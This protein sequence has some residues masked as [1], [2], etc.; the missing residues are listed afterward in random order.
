M[1]RELAVRIP[2][3]AREKFPDADNGY[4]SF[5]RLKKDEVVT[6]RLPVD[7]REIPA[8]DSRY[9]CIAR[10]PYLLA[11]VS[12]REECLKPLFLIDKECYRVYFN[13]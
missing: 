3:W 8:S 12:G 5:G 4:V 2:A 11:D 9:Y 10:G 1:K 6:L 7:I 13:K